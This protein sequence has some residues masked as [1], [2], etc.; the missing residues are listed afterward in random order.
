MPLIEK[1]KA[2]DDGST[3][4]LSAEHFSSR[5]KDKGLAKLSEIIAEFNADT[6]EVVYYFRRQ[7]LYFQ[8]WYSTYIKAGGVKKVSEIYPDLI[9]DKWFF[10]FNFVREKW[11]CYLPNAKVSLHSFD[12]IRKSG[13]I[14][15]HFFSNYVCTKVEN[16]DFNI[17]KEDSNLSWS[18][19]MI[20]LGRAINTIYG[21]N[22]NCRYMILE[23]IN[24]KIFKKKGG[25][26]IISART[27]KQILLQYETENMK[28]CEKL[29]LQ[30]EDVFK[31]I[32]YHEYEDPDDVRFTKESIL[33]LLIESPVW[34]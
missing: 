15:E 31:N 13:S 3:M 1:F 23:N 26:N 17:E 14:L 21:Q 27:S 25:G 10:D 9:K 24:K 12:S 7:D 19:Q 22:L 32:E 6:L 4:I 28:I 5:L 34:K 33:D 30:Y 2:L 18:S 16:F 11:E 8:S 29:N 20:A